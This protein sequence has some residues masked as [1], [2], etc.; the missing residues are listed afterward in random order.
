LVLS[1]FI[2]SNG[3]Y[4]NGGTNSDVVTTMVD[5]LPFVSKKGGDNKNIRDIYRPDRSNITII[6]SKDNENIQEICH[7]DR[8]KH[9]TNTTI[10][11][12]VYSEAPSTNKMQTNKHDI[13]TM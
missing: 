7:P 6:D 3:P 9:Y 5:N 1:D 13:T 2:E 11:Q 4:N 12:H 8:S 10:I